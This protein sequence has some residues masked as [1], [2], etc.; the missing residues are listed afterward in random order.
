MKTMKGGNFVSFAF[1]A[2]QT[3]RQV[4]SC[5]VVFTVT[6]FLFEFSTFVAEAISAQTG[7]VYSKNICSIVLI[8]HVKAAHM[9]QKIPTFL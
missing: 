2:R 4:F 8:F 9:Q 3:E 6:V 7:F 5:S 1:A